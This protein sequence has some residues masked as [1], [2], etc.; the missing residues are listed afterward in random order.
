ME[1]RWQCDG[2]GGGGVVVV[3]VMVGVKR[4]MVVKGLH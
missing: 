4:V 1:S 3:I 2:G